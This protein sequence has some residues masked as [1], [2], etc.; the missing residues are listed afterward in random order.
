MIKKTRILSALGTAVVFVLA[1]ASQAAAQDDD[2]VIIVQEEEQRGGLALG[3]ELGGGHMECEGEGCDGVTE[4][5][6][7]S[8][9]AGVLLTPNFGIMADGWI[10][11]HR[12]D[13]LTLTHSMATIGPQLWIGPFWVRGGVGVARAAFNYDAGIV[14]IG[15]KTETVPAAMAA[16]GLEVISTPDFAL[17]I[18]LRGGT[19]F[20]ND[21]DTQVQNVSLGLG[22]NWY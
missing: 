3:V 18:R 14:D 8:V 21:G 7:L 11:G 22:A 17:D 10:M 19:G 20:F 15:D 4:A 13:R 5:G 12:E 16:L 9:N 6:G 2:E 1:G